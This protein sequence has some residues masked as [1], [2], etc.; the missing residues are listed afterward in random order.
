M[1]NAAYLF[2]CKSCKEC[3][4]NISAKYHKCGGNKK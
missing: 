2:R 1:N 3:L 4:D